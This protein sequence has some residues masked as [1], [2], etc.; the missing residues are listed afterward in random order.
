MIV[1][2]RSTGSRALAAFLLLLLCAVVSAGPPLRPP[3]LPDTSA[4]DLNRN[5]INDRLDG[6]RA[7]LAGDTRETV[8][9][10]FRRPVTDA[11]LATFRGLG[12]TVTYV[13]Q[14][15]AYSIIGTIPLAATGRIPQAFGN[16]FYYLTVD[17]PIVPL[18]HDATNI[19][20]LRNAV[21]PTY[22]GAS[23]VRIA[24]L[25][26]GINGGH[27]DLTP[28]VVAWTD[29]S[30][31]AEPSAVDYHGHGTHCSGIA[32]GTGAHY[33]SAATTTLTLTYSGAMPTTKWSAYPVYINPTGSGNMSGSWTA[34]ESSTDSF[35]W[36][37]PTGVY[38][39]GVVPPAIAYGPWAVTAGV[40]GFGTGPNAAYSPA[41]HHSTLITFPYAI[42]AETYSHLSG[43]APLCNLVGVKVFKN[44]GS[45][46][47]S[48]ATAGADWVVSNRDTYNIKVASASIGV[49]DGGT[50]LTERAAFQS[51]MENGIVT[52][53]AA[54]NDYPT[55]KIGDPGLATKVITVAATS[56]LN[57]IASY[58]SNG[59]SGSGKPDCAATGGSPTAGYI[60]SLDTNNS[61]GQVQ[62]F[63]DVSA[64][65]YTPMM[66]TSMAT[67]LV[68]GICGLLVQAYEANIGAWPY[69]E[70]A[71][72]SIKNVLLCTCWETNRTGE[73]SN[74]PP[75]NR[76]AKDLVEGYGRVCPDAA[77]S[78]LNDP[79]TDFSSGGFG[80]AFS[81]ADTGLKVR[82]RRLVLSNRA[83]YQFSM[84]VPTGLDA[85]LY[86][87]DDT[88]DSTGN[89]VIV[90]SS[91]TATSAGNTESVTRPVIDI[92][93]STTQLYYLVA[94][95]VSGSGTAVLSDPIITSAEVSNFHVR[96]R[97]DGPELRWDVASDSN[98]AGFN[99]YRA[100]DPGG[101]WE[102]CNAKL[103]PVTGKTM[104]YRPE[105]ASARET[106]YY[107]LESAQISGATTDYGFVKA[108]ARR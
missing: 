105:S 69:T 64:D 7:V 89:P 21:W 94:K 48:Y 98:L 52:C 41:R 86:L 57:A 40:G 4:E 71:A 96:S 50:D 61:D 99:V 106:R 8:Q 24:V 23:G 27:N 26:T 34:Y 53:V 74:T 44:D 103:I 43:A 22:R 11:D 42:G 12:G 73:S 32:A 63:G 2:R 101:K 25:D 16:G 80:V 84:V 68:A 87:Y 102:R 6:R 47:T 107:R 55:Y 17:Q 20:R 49:K 66:G 5:G 83:S 30:P 90:L 108:A 62:T 35:P 67:P 39:D 45:G 104:V 46:Y 3:P 91:T 76:G 56:K 15:A 54:G 88:P 31:S 38:K 81:S 85:D 51:L 92:H 37:L 18:L 75:L 14:A 95:Q 9:V 59:A 97:P 79:W 33:G 78:C 77:V 93:D 58:S 1:S 100:T 65:D 70:A 29:T 19:V 60:I 13:C 28:R 72:L 36:W 82:A 10:L